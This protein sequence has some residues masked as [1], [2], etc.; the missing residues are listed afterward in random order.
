VFITFAE[1]PSIAKM[2]RGM[3]CFFKIFDVFLY[4][5][6]R[7][8]RKG[9]AKEFTAPFLKKHLFGSL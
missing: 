1:L 6:F 8:N 2:M 9:I 7:N 3:M 5:L 4:L